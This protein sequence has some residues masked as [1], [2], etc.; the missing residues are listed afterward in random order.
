MAIKMVDLYGPYERIR[1]EV[2]AGIREVV[3]SSAFINGPAVGEFARELSQY[4]G[5]RHTIPCGNGT[6]ALLLALMA[7]GLKA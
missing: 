4:L 7:I 1:E 2:A 6:D 5:V 3:E